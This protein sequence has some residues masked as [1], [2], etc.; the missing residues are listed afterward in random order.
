LSHDCVFAALSFSQ[1]SANC[2]NFQGVISFDE[3][4]A[5]KLSAS[6][7]KQSPMARQK[8]LWRWRPSCGKLFGIKVWKEQ[9]MKRILKWT[10]IAIV[11]LL[12]AAQFVRPAKT[13]PAVDES[14]TLE[15][16]AQMTPELQATLKRACY[17]C[18][19]NETVWPWYSNVA[20]VSWFVID[21]VKDGR[22]D[23]NFSEWS[24]YSK[25]RQAKKMAE[26][27][28][29]VQKDMMPLSSY[30]II[31]KEA[32]L[33]DADKKAIGDWAGAESQKLANQPA[34]NQNSK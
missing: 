20:P 31:H 13:N 16:H 12:I 10:G 32:K 26:I 28:E 5:D 25:Q 3:I 24:T 18:H 22:K 34:T 6:W 7:L 17:D 9:N 8:S 2:F 4:C 33:S 1:I 23:L 29:L 14:R 15:Q 19:S 27:Q 11:T 30:L 21:H